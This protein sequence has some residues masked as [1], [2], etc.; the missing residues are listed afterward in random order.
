MFGIEFQY[1][2]QMPCNGFSFAVLIGSQPYGFGVGS[3][4][5]Q[6]RYHFLFVGRYFI[7]RL[8]VVFNVDTEFFFLQVAYMA[9]AGKYLEIFSKEFFDGFSFGRRLNYNK[10]FLHKFLFCSDSCH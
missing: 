2:V 9:I 7:V 5:L 3:L 10:V 4:F 1:F 8:K 6:F